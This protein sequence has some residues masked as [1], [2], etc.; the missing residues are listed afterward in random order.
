MPPHVTRASDLKGNQRPIDPD[1]K[2]PAAVQRAAAAAEAAQRAAYPDQAPA[3]PAPTPAPNNDTISIAPPSATPTPVLQP[4]PAPTPAPQPSA[5]ETVTPPG[6]QSPWSQ[7][8][9]LEFHRIRSAEGRKRAD[10]ERAFTDQLSAAAERIASLEDLVEQLK[11]RVTAP[12]PTPPPAPARLITDQ[13]EQEFGSEMLDVMGRRAKESISP[14]LAE[15]RAMM[16]TL[17][18]KVD[19]TAQSVVKDKKKEMLLTLDR[20][21]PNWRQINVQ[22]E[23]K[24][25]LALQDPLFGVSRHSALLKAFGE[26]DTRRVLAFFTSF[27]SEQ[28]ASTPAIE[29]SVQDPPAPQPARPSLE[30]LA[31]P[32]RA[33]M[34]AQ[35]NAPAEKQIITT[36]DVNAF[37]DAVRKGLYNGREAE[38]Q[39]LEAELFAAQREGRVR[40]V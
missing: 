40:A 3:E 30:T 18:Q 19:G 9:E 39:A 12:A 31:A 7:E 1:V 27:N 28:A 2:V 22:P 10:L 26:N 16:S 5:A 25:W 21:M 33:R 14:E 8:V 11:Q 38:K 17:A 35:P 13:E 20:D 4:A 24:R 37:Y 34:S 32:G 6:N 23:F 15:L 29:P 36:A